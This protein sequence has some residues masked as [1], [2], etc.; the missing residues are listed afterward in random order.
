MARAQRNR[1]RVVHAEVLLEQ[2]PSLQGVKSQKWHLMLSILGSPAT[3]RSK[4]TVLSG[5]GL[6]A[7]GDA[8]RMH[9][10]QGF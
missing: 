8:I 3:P 7:K 4:E 2:S 9:Y 10:Q 5:K 6:F 1:L